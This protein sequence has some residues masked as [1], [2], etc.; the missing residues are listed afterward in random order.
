MKQHE[1]VILTLEKLGGVAT[2][3]QLYQRVSEIS[4]CA[5]GTKTP[6]ASIRR[7]VQLRP[8]ILKIK[9]G[10]YAL[11]SKRNELESKGLIAQSGHKESETVKKVDHS[12]YQGLL[13]LLGNLKGFRCWSPNQDKRKRF[14]DTSL[15]SLRTLNAI[16]GFSYPKLVKRSETIDVIWFNQRE[17]PSRF[18]EIE[19]STDIQNSL[20][21]FNDL[22]DFHT[23]MFIVADQQRRKE[24]ESKLRYSS[25]CDINGR[26]KFLS[27]DWLVKQYEHAVEASQQEVTL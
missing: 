17:M 18:F 7:I 8:E 22:R 10:L 20:L 14:L 19:Q 27:Y 16:P 12:Y 23:E 11:A 2:L 5:W 13:L 9:P 26:V 3:G 21:K 15:E 24:F 4:D 6:F 1:A 25:F